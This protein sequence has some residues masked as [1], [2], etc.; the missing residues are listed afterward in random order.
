M[1]R[2]ASHWRTLIRKEDL[3]SKAT[4]SKLTSHHNRARLLREA[5]SKI[6]SSRDTQSV[7]AHTQTELLGGICHPLEEAA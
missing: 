2:L 3:E 1:G 4:R 5:R 6:Q 7:L